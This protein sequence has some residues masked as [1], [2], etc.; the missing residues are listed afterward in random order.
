MEPERD[1]QPLA[2][3]RSYPRAR[4]TAYGRTRTPAPAF[5]RVREVPRLGPVRKAVFPVAGLDT[6][7]LP[8]TKAAPKEMLTVVDKPLI[9]YAVEEAISAG[10]REMVFVTS[11]HKRSIEDHFDMAYD[12][13]ESLEQERREE[14]LAELRRHFPSDVRYLYVRQ[15]E[16]GGLG[17]ALMCAQALLDGAPF[18]VIVPDELIDAPT[19]AIGQLIASFNTMQQPVIGVRRAAGGEAAEATLRTGA[20]FCERTHHVVRFEHAERPAAGGLVPVGR[21]VLTP[22][23]FQYLERTG[24]GAGFPDL[25]AALREVAAEQSLLAYEIE[26]QRFACG[27]KLGLLAANV[28]Y[29]LKHPDLA[30]PFAELLRSVQIGLQRQAPRFATSAPRHVESELLGSHRA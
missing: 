28:H 15:R 13:E 21:Y 30:A 14:L 4:Y 23:I 22:R 6:G 7:F 12:L 25:R 16:F 17:S 24:G 26:G 5:R 19:P 9:H 18:A 1:L 11:R 3:K 20:A 29:G 27:S 2:R 10:I 8:A